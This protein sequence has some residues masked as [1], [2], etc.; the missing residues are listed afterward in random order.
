MRTLWTLAFVAASLM[1]ASAQDESN[2]G[3]WDGPFDVGANVIHAS[4]LPT[5]EVIGWSEPDSYAA[6]HLAIASRRC[7]TES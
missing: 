7:I 1:E 2:N 5:G 6:T 3:R 4:L